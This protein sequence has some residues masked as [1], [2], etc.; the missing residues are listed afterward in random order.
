ME[1]LKELNPEQKEKLTQYLLEF[2]SNHKQEI[3]AKNLLQRTRYLT[4]VLE[5]VFQ[6]HNISAVLR[7][8]ECFGVQDVHIIENRNRYQVNP[9]VALGASKWLS[10]HRYDEGEE[11]VIRVLERIRAQ[12]YRLVATSPHEDDYTIE[13]LPLDQ[14][15]ALIFG[16]ELEGLSKAALS[17]ADAWVKIPMVGFTESLN[18][19]VSAAVSLYTLTRRLRQS[20]Y[21]WRLNEEEQQDVLLQWAVSAVKS[22]EPLI[23]N[24]LNQKRNLT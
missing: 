11:T 7:S 16:T 6:P 22:A 14:K 13:E 24:F 23:K 17:M 20:S 9:D 12:G 21:S 2:V 19:S 10:I 8:C 18:I 4:I 5:N 3:F 1:L 15:T